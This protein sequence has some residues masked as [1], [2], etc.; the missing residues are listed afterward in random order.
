MNTPVRDFIPENINDIKQDIRL[1]EH[2]VRTFKE[3][4]ILIK[5]KKPFIFPLS[6][7]NFERVFNQS[8]IRLLFGLTIIMVITSSCH[9]TSDKEKMLAAK[10][11]SAH[12]CMKVPQRFSKLST[13]SS[14]TNN[15]DTSVAGMAYIKGGIFMMG[16][17]NSQAASDEYPKHSVRIALHFILTKHKLPMHNFKNLWMPRIILPRPKKSLIGKK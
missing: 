4:M 2:P 13:D 3:N 14:I 15:G 7:A 16:G 12:S 5:I 11:D 17:D 10:N 9:N 8:V 6:P 1:K